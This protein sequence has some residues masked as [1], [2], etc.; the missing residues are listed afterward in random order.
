MLKIATPLVTGWEEMGVPLSRI[1]TEPFG[2]GA[3]ELVTAAVS[4]RG[5]P[6]GAV[7]ARLLLRVTRVGAGLT[8]MAELIAERV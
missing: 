5:D 4:A 7:A 6:A 2:F 1:V 3:V 8:V